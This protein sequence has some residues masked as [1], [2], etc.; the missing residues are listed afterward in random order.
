MGEQ[1]KKALLLIAILFSSYCVAEEAAK[2]GSVPLLPVDYFGGL[3]DVGYVT[4]SPDGKKLASFV[5]IDTDKVKGTSVQVVNLESGKSKLVLF[6]DNIKFHFYHMSWKNDKTLLVNIFYPHSREVYGPTLKSRET[7]LIVVHLDSDEINNIFSNSFL[8]RYTEKPF[9]KDSVVDLLPD[10]DDYLLMAVGGPL[11]GRIGFAPGVFKVNVRNQ[12]ADIVMEPARTYTWI[13]DQQHRIRAAAQ[14]DYKGD[15]TSIMVRSLKDD[16]W[17]EL[18]KYD[19]FYSE[20]YAEALGFGADPNIFYF[21]AY[22]NGRSAVY[23]VDLSGD[24]WKPELVRADPKYDVDGTLIYSRKKKDVIGI[25]SSYGVDQVFL[26]PEYQALQSMINKALPNTHNRLYSFSDD[27]QRYLV[28]SE[29]DV[30]SGTYYLG[31]RG[32]GSLEILAFSYKNL[33]ADQLA[34]TRPYNYR[35]RDDWD[36]EGFLTIPA[37]AKDKQLPVIVLPHGGPQYSDTGRFDYWTQF[38]AN[39][40]YAVFQP[41]FRGST[42]KGW[43]FRNAGLM[44]RSLDAQNDIEDG[45]KKLIA[46]GIADPKRICI[47]GASYGGYSA[48]L[49]ATR[50]PDLYACAISVAGVSDQTERRLYDEEG[51]RIR[52]GKLLREISPV[53]YV[54]NVK[55]P[56]LLIH[57]EKDR[58]VEFKQSEIMYKALKKARKTVSLVALQDQ[59]HFLDNNENRIKTFVEMDK[60]LKKYLPTDRMK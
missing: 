7:D 59:D 24:E 55:I 13:A 47:V 30:N 2:T 32:K 38:F 58:Q 12:R 40:G 9:D 6:S 36:I 26:D 34:H 53:N 42:G 5:K 44:F 60:F 23:K 39:R 4:L 52:D 43:K 41:N 31:D 28:Y 25:E 17:K 15:S 54:K 29:S 16:K 57:G 22:R 51:E 35:T 56:I 18:L 1:M 11:V 19:S 49:S 14:A 48:L 8:A 20:D 46:D 45:V 21:R 37:G 3:P 10:D 33:H 27:E 50:K